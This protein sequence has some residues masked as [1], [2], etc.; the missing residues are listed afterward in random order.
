MR[1]DI[2]D[3]VP[4]NKKVVYSFEMSRLVLR[5]VLQFKAIANLFTELL[6]LPCV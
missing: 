5:V 3:F 2:W 6:S 1:L 4:A